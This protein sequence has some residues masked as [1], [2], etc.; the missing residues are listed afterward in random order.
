MD[1][2]KLKSI[3][4]SDVISVT[5]ETPLSKALSILSEKKISCLL[6]VENNKPIGI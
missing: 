6:V 1:T 2:I 4:S 5:Q 3:L